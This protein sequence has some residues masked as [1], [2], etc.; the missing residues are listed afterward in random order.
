LG[1]VA[2]DDGA[3]GLEAYKLVARGGVFAVKSP[4]E[5]VADR[6]EDA[7]HRGASIVASRLFV[8]AK[9]LGYPMGEIATYVSSAYQHAYDW[10]Q[11]LG[12]VGLAV[13]FLAVVS[14]V[15]A[16]LWLKC[17]NWS[18]V[19]WK[20]TDYAY[21]LFAILG[22]AAAAADIAVSNWTKQLD[23]IEMNMLTNTLL[24]REYVSSAALACEKKE[25][26]ERKRA[27]FGKDVISPS[28]NLYDNPYGYPNG[29]TLFGEP[30]E[31]LVTGSDCKTVKRIR[32]DIEDNGLKSAEEYGFKVESGLSGFTAYFVGLTG[33]D[34]GIMYKVGRSLVQ[35]DSA[36]AAENAI[37]QQL[38]AIS[39]LSILKSLSPILLGLGIGIRL[40]RTHYDVRSEEQK[41]RSRAED[42]T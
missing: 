33:F 19:F 31:S 15:F 38:S 30:V 3:V 41:A 8:I 6:A 24:F 2:E 18:A 10:W 27:E 37:K 1:T 42:L 14:V 22:G 39:Y 21:F 7:R 35:I 25:E 11:A 9:G 16:A 13:E 20:R 12:P 32:S 40:S 17:R 28:D 29:N 36:K 26:L 5:F 4:V 34:R 23:Q